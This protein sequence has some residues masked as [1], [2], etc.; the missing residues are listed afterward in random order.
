MV[1][2]QNGVLPFGRT[3]IEGDRGEIIVDIFIQFVVEKMITGQ[4]HKNYSEQRS[5]RLSS[6]VRKGDFVLQNSQRKF[7]V[8]T[9]KCWNDSEKEI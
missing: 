4:C 5:S 2:V 7:G 6:N 8:L 1:E 3:S 9:E